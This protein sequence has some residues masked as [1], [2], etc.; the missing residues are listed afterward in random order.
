M[1]AEYRQAIACKRLFSPVWYLFVWKESHANQ[2]TNPLGRTNQ[3]QRPQSPNQSRRGTQAQRP[4][5]CRSP[6][7]GTMERGMERSQSVMQTTQTPLTTG[8]LADT[9]SASSINNNKLYPHTVTNPSTVFLYSS[10]YHTHHFSH[11]ATQVGA[12]FFQRSWAF[13]QCP[14]HNTYIY[15]RDKKINIYI[16][17][18]KWTQIKKEKKK[19][20]CSSEIR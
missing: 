15:I 6:A 19:S 2:K 11:L 3:A 17:G 1:Q 13:S 16:Y 18:Y 14:A 5:A 9:M 7:T 12:L 20:F 4:K 8:K 10:G